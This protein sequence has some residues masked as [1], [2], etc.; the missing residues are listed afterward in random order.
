[1]ADIIPYS[2]FDPQIKQ[3]SL[4]NAYWCARAA[5]LVYQ[6]ETEILGDLKTTWGMSRCVYIN[7]V[8]ADTQGFVAC[9][10]KRVILAF[11]GT[12]TIEDWLTDIK[13]RRVAGPFGGVHRGFKQALDA[14]WDEVISV[15]SDMESSRK[16]LWICGHS[17][18]AALATLAAAYLSD[19]DN[20]I[21]GVYTFG[22]PRVGDRD[23]VDAYD[24][25][26]K[27]QTNRFISDEDIVT[28]V[29]P[30]AVGYE[31][32]G[33]ARFFDCQGTLHNGVEFWRRWMSRSEGV[34][35]RSLER[36]RELKSQY[37]NSIADHA[38]N[39]YVT[40]IRNAWLQ[41]KKQSGKAM[42]FKEHINS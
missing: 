3:F 40:R 27:R 6:S 10:E 32:V 11:R 2:E 38:T 29:P 7:N 37:P 9:D 1:M 24:A 15:L 12:Q 22:S 36:Y 23:F 14:V 39:L 4:A 34:A 16:V 19:T 20:E 26:L 18:G 30:R 28:R 25:R 31:H 17:L 8:E 33:V 21:N 42:S 5:L 35:V 41:E 13:V